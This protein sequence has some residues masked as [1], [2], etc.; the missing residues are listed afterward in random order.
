MASH[1]AACTGRPLQISVDPDVE[2]E[3]DTAHRLVVSPLPLHTECAAL[4]GGNQASQYI[5]GTKLPYQ[6]QPHEPCELEQ[7]LQEH[8][9][10]QIYLS[11]KKFTCPFGSTMTTEIKHGC[12]VSLPKNLQRLRSYAIY[13][14]PEQNRKDNYRLKIVSL[15]FQLPKETELHSGELILAPVRLLKTQ[16]SVPQSATTSENVQQSR[17][18]RSELADYR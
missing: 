5:T 17:V 18:L 16:I 3:I 15:Y 11:W 13:N 12:M 8:C 6:R 4:G 1:C 7:H 14:H 10:M 2:S 9:K